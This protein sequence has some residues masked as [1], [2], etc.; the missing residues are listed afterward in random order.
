MI[1]DGFQTPK[2]KNTGINF[3]KEIEISNRRRKNW[4]LALGDGKLAG[5]DFAQLAE[6][7]DPY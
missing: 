4:I 3:Q 2:K 5:E 7:E 6:K 1:N